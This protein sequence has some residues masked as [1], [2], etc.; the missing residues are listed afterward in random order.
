MSSGIAFM[1]FLPPAEQ[2]EFFD[3]YYSGSEPQN[4]A[5]F[6]PCADGTRRTVRELVVM[7]QHG[8]IKLS[9][10]VADNGY[11]VRLIVNPPPTRIFTQNTAAFQFDLTSMTYAASCVI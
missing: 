3:C 5:V 7:P 1:R 8:N 9:T 4:P 2:R 6:V 11:A 10:D